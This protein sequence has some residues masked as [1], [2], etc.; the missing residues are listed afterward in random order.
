MANPQ[1][2][3][4]SYCFLAALTENQND[5]YNHVYV[6]ICKR[7]LSLYSLRGST[8][9]TAQDIQ[10]IIQEEYGVKVPILVVRKLIVSV[11]KSLSK[12]QK[13]QFDA[14]IFAH[15]D[16]FQ[17]TQYSFTD[18]ENKYKKGLRDAAKLQLSFRDYLFS[19]QIDPETLP[20]FSEFLD[21]NKQQI[22]SF[23]KGNGFIKKDDIDKT[24]ICHVQFLEYIDTTNDELF[25]IAEQLYLGSIVAGFLESGIDL[26]PKFVSDEVYYLDTPLILRALDLQK[27][28]DTKPALELLELI[29]STGGTIKVLSVTL[30]ELNDVINNAVESYNNKQ[31][32]T[33]IND[34]CI[35]LG[36]NKAWLINIGAK[37][38][39]YI[40]ENL[41]IDKETISQALLEKFEKSPDVKALKETRKKKGN[42]F[43]DVAAYL[44]VREQRGA[45]ISTFQKGKYWFVTMNYDLLLFNK[46]HTTISGVTE[47]TLPDTLTSMLWLKDPAKLT[48]QVKKVGLRELMATTLSEEIA[49]KE[50]IGEF[51]TA[52]SSLD[53]VSEED[54]QILLESVAH[55]S[56]KKITAFNDLTAQDKNAAKQQAISIIEKEKTRNAKQAQILKEAQGEKKQ[57]EDANTILNQRVKLLEDGQL[58]SKT[59]IER[60]ASQLIDQKKFIKKAVLGFILAVILGF[61][62]IWGFK[63]FSSILS[64]ILASISS[65]GGLWGFCSLIIN[66]GKILFKK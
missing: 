50:L 4:T 58:Q 65:F 12:R 36:K 34:A 38:E 56:A 51:E 23:F 10:E 64:R 14:E 35:R 39:T 20:T 42:A 16:S 9:G 17:L 6:P 57:T 32:I 7:A 30:S 61:F 28:E 44:F 31:P 45:A 11:L 5:L 43:H 1:D 66:L 59:E 33:T 37:I 48:M 27:E 41:K 26:E 29:K 55:Q 3:L 60:L 24:Y 21:K 49:S 52:I 18:L 13:V 2:T 62:A 40:H 63:N 47:I 46:E 8:H 22:A 19:E 54:Y 25:H 15:G 53:D